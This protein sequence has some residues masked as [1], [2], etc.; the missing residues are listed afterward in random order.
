MYAKNKLLILLVLFAF[1][2]YSQGNGTQDGMAVPKVNRVIPIAESLQ[3]LSP[4]TFYCQ[5]FEGLYN[6]NS[7]FHDTGGISDSV[8]SISEVDA[9]SG[10]RAIQNSYFP[11]SSFKEGDDPGASGWVWQFFGDNKL[12]T[13][14]KDTTPRTRVFARWHHKF[15]EGFTSQE[16]RGT[17]PP[18]MARM[19]CF[20]TPWNAVYTVYFW[21]E[22]DK[23]LISIQQK[24]NAPDTE[25]EW[26]P[27]YNTVFYLNEPVNL[28]RWIHMELGVTL[29]EGRRSDHVQAWADGKLIC[30]LVNQDLAGGYRQQTLNGM[31]WDCYWNGGSPRRQSRFY[32]D[33]M[34]SSEPIGPARTPV[35]PVIE[36]AGSTGTE[37]AWESKFQVEVAR[38]NQIPLSVK[39]PARKQPVM[40]YTT[41][42]KG[43]TQGFSIE[44]NDCYGEFINQPGNNN[45][46]DYNTLYSVRLRQKIGDS[47]WTDWSP[48]H[49]GFATVWEPGTLPENRVL[50]QGYLSGH[51]VETSVYSAP[52]NVAP[53]REYTLY[54]NPAHEKVFINSDRP[55]E[56]GIYSITGSL[57]LTQRV[58]ST[59][60][61]I[62]ISALPKGIYLVRSLNTHPLTLKMVAW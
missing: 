31:Q 51:T 35:Q 59:G 42:W 34:L 39:D 55:T 1:Q 15:E 12:S 16:D 56:V 3:E 57:L 53:G 23:G 45:S 11:K 33:L 13:R 47:E 19:R 24:T 6:L 7:E 54:P 18:K 32:D 17:L 49:A 25:R 58:E 43:N 61:P 9:Y 50:P 20:T 46:L 21:I 28:G 5:N 14:I 40:E 30:D 41:V 60:D 8:M 10:N 36:I 29:G 4:A 37:D 44:V 62:D 26:L 27:N 2:A 52:E 22:E 48:W 38:T